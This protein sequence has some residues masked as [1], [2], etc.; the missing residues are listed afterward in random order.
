MGSLS[1]AGDRMRAKG[2]VGL[3]TK[4]AKAAGESVSSFAKAKAGAGGK[5]GKEA[6]FARMA[7]RHFKPLSK[8][9]G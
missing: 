9:K 8:G 2:T 5:L 6:N 1:E 3:F 4:K 7:Q